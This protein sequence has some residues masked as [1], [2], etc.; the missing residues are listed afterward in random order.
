MAVSATLG[1][2]LATG[3]AALS[4]LRDAGRSPGTSLH[5]K[6]DA[7]HRALAVPAAERDP[8]TVT[9]GDDA[10]QGQADA[11]AGDAAGRPAPGELVPD[12]VGLVLRDP[13]P[14]VGYLQHYP[15]AVLAGAYL[16]CVARRG[17]L[18][19]VGDQVLE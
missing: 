9:H 14:G 1:G 7:D 11:G 18:D 5:G 16:N 13:G 2:Y 10:D 8:P 19:R 15:A 12:L 3:I 17:E 6:A 4:R